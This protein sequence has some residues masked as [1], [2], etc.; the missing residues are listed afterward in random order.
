[1]QGDW[2]RLIYVYFRSLLLKSF[3]LRSLALFSVLNHST[4]SLLVVYQ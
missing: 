3:G 1:M 2:K 4:G